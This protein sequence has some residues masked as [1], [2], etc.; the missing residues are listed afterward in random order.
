MSMPASIEVLIIGAGPS[1]LFAAIELARR[2]VQARVV[3]REPGPHTQARATAI[4]PGTLEIFARA[5]VVD[6]VLAESV[7]LG[8][9]RLFDARVRQVGEIAF[10]GAGCP[11]EFQCSLPQWRTERI[12]ADRLAE[13]GGTV[14]RG[15]EAVSVRQRDDGVLIGLKQA[16]GTADTV[17][18]SWVIGAGGAHSVTRESMAETLV[19]TTYP[20]TSL[21]A[22]G[23]MT[24]DLPRDGS[25]L[26]ASPEGWVLVVPLPGGHWLT[27]VGDLDE[28]EARRLTSDPA[29]GAV[30]AMI[31][32]RVARGI[33]MQEVAW[34]APFRMHR[35]L[36]PQL[37]DRRCFLLGDAGHL[38]SPFGGEGLNSGIHDGYNLG[39]KLAL[40]LRG[41]GR[42]R[43][44]ESFAAER[45]AADRR[46][47]MVSDRLHELAYRA[48]ESARTGIV[49]VPPTP[50]EVAAMVQTRSMLDVSYAG[51]SL[52]GEYPAGTRTPMAPAP[53]DRYPDRA[54]LAGTDHHLLLFSAAEDADVM[55][56]RH[57]W[58]GLVEISHATGDPRRA[59]LATGDAVLVRP[60]GHI[61][62]RAPANSVGLGALDSHLDSYLIPANA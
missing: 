21:V 18:A 52:V 56:L 58:R 46:V 20:G 29:T 38:S 26:I 50:A 43:L 5:G 45:L 44:L 25:A 28:G 23:T 42:P 12:L 11:W 2:G 62:F 22:S 33:R 36:V 47:L 30:A 41:H 31:E 61:G 32:R 3:E 39:W 27:F 14:E 34:A 35:R 55:R 48:V 4:Q 19:G 40:E 24:C 37:A 51:S 7:H 57:R 1:G 15:V 10:A 9:A 59:G 49:P 6:R 60:D 8:F 17:E 16:D 53:G 54:A 13:L